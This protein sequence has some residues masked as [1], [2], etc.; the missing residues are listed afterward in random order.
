MISPLTVKK[1]NEYIKAHYV[2]LTNGI[3]FSSDSKYTPR[4]YMNKLRGDGDTLQSRLEHQA[5]TFTE[6][7]NKLLIDSNEDNPTIYKAA[8]IS[9]QQ[10]S[11]IISD[12]NYTPKKETILALAVSL[13]QDVN[14]TNN[15][16]NK[17]GYALTNT[18]KRDVIVQYFIELEKFD[19]QAINEALYYYKLPLLGSKIREKM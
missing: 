10:F 8:N 15:L 12:K 11:R 7:L 5:E 14:G 13:R 2:P 19:I 4:D 9:K 17:A 16:L 3:S 18:S 1:I 6:Y